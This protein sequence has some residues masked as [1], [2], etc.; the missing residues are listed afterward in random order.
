M[1]LFT[2]EGLTYPN[3]LNLIKALKEQGIEANITAGGVAVT[4]SPD[5]VN[6]AELICTQHKARFNPG[7]SSHQEDVML[8]GGSIEHLAQV[9]GDSISVIS[10]WKV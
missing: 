6:Q 5:Q 1:A 10:E 9:T 8:Q 3:A 7:Y 2:A 4:A